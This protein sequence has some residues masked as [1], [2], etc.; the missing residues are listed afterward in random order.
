MNT[1]YLENDIICVKESDLY[2]KNGSLYINTGIK[3]IKIKRNIRELLII[4]LN[5]IDK[6]ISNLTNS[7]KYQKQL[8]NYIYEDLVSGPPGKSLDTAVYRRRT[9]GSA[10]GRRLPR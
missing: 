3:H 9:R 6:I 5:N 8:E 4:L 1:L 7:P 2:I 10:Q